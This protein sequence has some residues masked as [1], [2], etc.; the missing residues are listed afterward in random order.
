MT[1]AFRCLVA[2]L[3]VGACAHPVTREQWARCEEACKDGGGI[4]EACKESFKGP[5]C[6]C[7][8]DQIIWLDQSK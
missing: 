8:N 7:M 2:S 1:I 3:F 4:K 6:H 5:G